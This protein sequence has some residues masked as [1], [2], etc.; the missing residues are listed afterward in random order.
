MKDWNDIAAPVGNPAGPAP[1]RRPGSIRRTST[2]DTTWPEGKIGI[3]LMQGHARDFYTP[4]DGSPPVVLAEDSFTA[5]VSGTREILRISSEPERPELARL[6]GSRAGGHLRAA[7]GEALPKEL[8]A[9]TPLYLLL[10][11]LAG[12]SLVAM[13]AWSRWSDHWLE[14]AERSGITSTAGR[15]GSMEG[16]VSAIGRAPARWRRKAARPRS[17]LARRSILCA[18]PMIRQAGMI[19]RCK[20]ALACDGR[21]GSMSGWMNAF[22]SIPAFR[23][24]RPRRPAA[25]RR[26][27]NTAWPRRRTGKPAAW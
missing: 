10:D 15:N 5:D 20:A 16:S 6:A 26:C 9:G 19:W 1:P 4:A 12:A 3:M 27:M 14:D 22:T 18:I 21:D 23:I 17:R 11:D 7:I 2:I 24:A 8:R 25:G 13:W